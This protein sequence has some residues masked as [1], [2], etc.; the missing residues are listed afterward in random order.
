MK[1]C[2]SFGHSIVQSDICVVFLRILREIFLSDETLAIR[3]HQILNIY[4]FIC[5]VNISMHIFSCIKA[6]FLIIRSILQR[7]FKL[8]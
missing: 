6:T 1:I 4:Y 2:Y 5:H 8:K 7:H 3:K